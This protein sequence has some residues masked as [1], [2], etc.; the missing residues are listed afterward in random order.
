LPPVVNVGIA[1]TTQ[2][3]EEEKLLTEEKEAID[4]DGSMGEN[5]IEKKKLTEGRRGGRGFQPLRSLC[6]PEQSPLRSVLQA[7][8]ELGVMTRRRRGGLSMRSHFG[9][10]VPESVYPGWVGGKG[11]RCGLG[12]LG[13]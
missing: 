2:E 4:T 9:I 8:A 13:C 3:K 7:V 5:E 1:I 6:G 10:L 11:C 12:E